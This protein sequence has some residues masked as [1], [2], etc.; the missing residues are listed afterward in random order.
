MVD[1]ADFFEPKRKGQ[2]ERRDR[3][4]RRG[5]PPVATMSFSSNLKGFYVSTDLDVILDKLTEDDEE[6]CRIETCI[7]INALNSDAVSSS[8]GGQVKFGDRTYLY[9]I[10]TTSG[11]VL[12]RMDSANEAKTDSMVIPWT[13]IEH[14]EKAQFDV[15]RTEAFQL[16]GCTPKGRERLYLLR[17]I[18]R[19]RCGR[20]EAAVEPA[21]RGKGF[22]TLGKLREACFPDKKGAKAGS[23]SLEPKAAR[24]FDDE[25]EEIELLA[26]EPDSHLYT[27]SSYIWLE[28]KINDDRKYLAPLTIRKPQASDRD[29]HEENARFY[30]NLMILLDSKRLVCKGDAVALKELVK[31]MH[32]SSLRDGMHFRQI[33]YYSSK[34]WPT[35]VERL[36]TWLNFHLGS[37]TEAKV[38]SIVDTDLLRMGEAEVQTLEAQ[39]QKWRLDKSDPGHTKAGP[40]SSSRRNYYSDKFRKLKEWPFAFTTKESAPYHTLKQKKWCTFVQKAVNDHVLYKI[41]YVIHLVYYMVKDCAPI[42]DRL[43]WLLE[44]NEEE[45]LANEGCHSCFLNLFASACRCLKLKHVLGLK[46]MNVELE[47]EVVSILYY[48]LKFSE[49]AAES[50]DREPLSFLAKCL[51]AMPSSDVEFLIETL[52]KP[53]KLNVASGGDEVGSAM[54]Y[55]LYQTLYLAAR[56]IKLRPGLLRSFGQQFEVDWK[57][58]NHQLEGRLDR[59]KADL[60]FLNKIYKFEYEAIYQSLKETQRAM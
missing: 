38:T 36:I 15:S 54:T 43:Y 16:F 30:H 3:E 23:E 37:S 28:K 25:W 13:L 39:V 51:E 26:I 31:T 24:S 50:E 59:T 53:G 41:R 42:Q 18:V 6:I 11:I 9:V 2:G 55:E 48:I 27:T 34:A 10:L 44:P 32:R 14:I 4:G 21:Q 49:E 7:L 5:Q 12:S 46:G 45:K 57:Y 33:F 58:Y 19:R 20:E 52:L 29:M 17:F 60:S 47:M 56:I 8:K 22:S 35:L 40:H 1:F